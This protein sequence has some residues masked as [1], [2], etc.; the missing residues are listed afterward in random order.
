M[1]V[2]KKLKTIDIIELTPVRNRI[3]LEKYD[4]RS[5][6]IFYKVYALKEWFDNYIKEE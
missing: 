4:E 3:Y 5:G 6:F 2:N 1:K